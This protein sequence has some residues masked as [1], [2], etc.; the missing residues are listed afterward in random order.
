MVNNIWFT[1]HRSMKETVL[2]MSTDAHTHTHIMRSG[3]RQKEVKTKTNMQGLWPKVGLSALVFILGSL[4]SVCLYELFIECRNYST[5]VDETELQGC[6][7]GE[8]QS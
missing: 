6:T 1:Q 2:N 8:P 3:I 4:L 5:A 7:A